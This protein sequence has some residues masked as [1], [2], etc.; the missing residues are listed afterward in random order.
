[1]LSSVYYGMLQK[2]LT[3]YYNCAHYSCS[4]KNRDEFSKVVFVNCL[5]Q[6]TAVTIVYCNEIDKTISMKSIFRLLFLLYTTS[7]FFFFF[8]NRN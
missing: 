4:A 8:F 1:M 3:N 7:S 5:Q 6:A 2:L